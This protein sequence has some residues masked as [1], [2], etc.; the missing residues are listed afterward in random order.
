[1]SLVT[2]NTVAPVNISPRV[3][4]ENAIP[5]DRAKAASLHI[6]ACHQLILIY[7]LVSSHLEWQIGTITVVKSGWINMRL[8]NSI[9]PLEVRSMSIKQPK[10]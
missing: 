5:S 3:I 8:E 10:P 7:G 1:M 2:L 6:P 4:P 9:W